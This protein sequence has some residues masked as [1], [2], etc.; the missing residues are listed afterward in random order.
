MFI[1]LSGLSGAQDKL[2]VEDK[3]AD[4]MRSSGVGV[5]ITTL[6]D[7]LAFLA[8]S[9]TNYIAVKNFCI[10]TGIFKFRFLRQITTIHS[11]MCRI[12]VV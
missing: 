5:T 10:Y 3:M 8:G 9:F 12:I 7:L 11:N 1:L 6:T 4:T 2:T